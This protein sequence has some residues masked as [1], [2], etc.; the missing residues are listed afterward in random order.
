MID[1]PK[2]QKIYHRPPK[3]II[4]KILYKKCK[5]VEKYTFFIK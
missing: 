5:R 4:L 3:N 2:K 1:I